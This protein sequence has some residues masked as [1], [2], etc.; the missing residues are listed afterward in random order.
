MPVL[1]FVLFFVFFWGGVRFTL[2]AFSS[3][4]G[5]YSHFESDRLKTPNTNIL[6]ICNC[7]ADRVRDWLFFL[8]EAYEGVSKEVEQN[9]NNNRRHGYKIIK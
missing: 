6:L 2:W 8:L 1:F 4:L 5:W 7:K 9:N 3:N